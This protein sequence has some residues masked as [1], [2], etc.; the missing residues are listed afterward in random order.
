M[1]SGPCCFVRE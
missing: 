1:I